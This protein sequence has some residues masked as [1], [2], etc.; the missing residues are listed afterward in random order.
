MSHMPENFNPYEVSAS[1]A[2]GDITE[3]P[4]EA[5]YR[6]KLITWIV[7]FLLNLPLPLF[8]GSSMV[9]GA[10]VV[11][12]VSAILFLLMAGVFA[13]S[14]FPR[15]LSALQVGGVVTAVSQ[16][17][18]ILHM[19]AGVVAMS[20]TH[21]IVATAGANADDFNVMPECTLFVGG[22]CATFITAGIVLFVAAA[23]G[24][25]VQAVRRR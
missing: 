19:F 15:L 6:K 21:Q 24:G 1:V 5:S 25:L 12:M 3:A 7:V 23:I 9:A 8:F 22:F 2:A 20:V 17:L 4:I 13:T 11:G 18:P 10:G 16:F 14:R